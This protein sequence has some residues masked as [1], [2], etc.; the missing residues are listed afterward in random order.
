[1]VLP[2]ELN[3]YAENILRRFPEEFMALGAPN[4]EDIYDLRPNGTWSRKMVE[5]SAEKTIEITMRRWSGGNAFVPG[6]PMGPMAI[7]Q[8]LAPPQA[9]RPPLSSS[10]AASACCEEAWSAAA[11]AA[12]FQGAMPTAS[13]NAVNTQALDDQANQRLGRLEGALL[14]LK[15][16]IEAMVAIQSKLTTQVPNHANS[17]PQAA[18]R[19]AQTPGAELKGDESQELRL[20]RNLD[21]LQINTAPGEK[22]RPQ[23][24]AAPVQQVPAPAPLQVPAQ[25]H[26]AEAAQPAD[27]KPKVKVARPTVEIPARVEIP[28]RSMNSTDPQSPRSPGRF[29]AWK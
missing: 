8:P 28:S 26:Q 4:L 25:N 23:V 16:Q 19:G 12:R 24:Q 1:M 11:A 21:K 2:P 13:V 3:I 7:P 5:S 14:A 9:L 20:R 29:S 15:P 18:P 17:N 22:S 10:V 6:Y 27:E